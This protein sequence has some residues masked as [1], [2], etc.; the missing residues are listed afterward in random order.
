[1]AV[2][3]EFLAEQIQNPEDTS[4]IFDKYLSR[5]EGESVEDFQQRKQSIIEQTMVL[6]DKSPQI[7]IVDMNMT[8]QKVPDMNIT[9]AEK[10]AIQA[11]TRRLAIKAQLELEEKE[12]IDIKHESFQ[13]INNGCLFTMSQIKSKYPEIE[14]KINRNTVEIIRQDFVRTLQKVPLDILQQ[15]ENVR[16]EYFDLAD[17][18]HKAIE[19]QNELKATQREFEKT[20][21]EIRYRLL[22]SQAGSQT[23]QPKHPPFLFSTVESNIC[24]NTTEVSS[25]RNNSFN[26]GLSAI[27]NFF[28]S[29]SK[30]A[31]QVLS[32]PAPA[33][34]PQTQSH[35][36][37][38]NTS[39]QFFSKPAPADGPKIQS[40]DTINYE[41]D[42]SFKISLL[43][44]PGVGTSHLRH[45]FAKNIYFEPNMLYLN[46]RYVSEIKTIILNKF[47]IKLQIRT[48]EAYSKTEIINWGE[49]PL[50]YHTWPAKKDERRIQ[51][52]H[53]K[54]VRADAVIV[55]FDITDYKIFENLNKWI[56][57][58]DPHSN[59]TAR[60]L[61]ATKCD[62][63]EAE[64]AVKKEEIRVFAE[65]NNLNVF[66]TSAKDNFNVDELFE[67]VAN[68]I[69]QK[70][71]HKES[72]EIIPLV[73]GYSKRR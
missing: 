37:P 3:P 44:D 69:I 29:A 1:M 11:Y 5:K 4:V 46:D 52:N 55:V 56:D 19:R 20:W 70:K 72:E 9:E 38:P 26:A 59:S 58:T 7:S 51:F 16:N 34:G 23:F 61:A 39:R 17:N 64:W 31:K 67:Y 2:T 24:A 42:Y 10:Q 32:N 68:S 22:L 73:S 33:E 65:E 25:S 30:I 13:E 48:A 71:K 57:E 40:P 27:G 62:I 43:G 15:Y 45:R 41:G 66:F 54:E 28:T 36:S 60:T 18:P 8:Q 6:I 47:R 12:G 35:V 14:A 63:P 49:E 53:S 50:K 21:P